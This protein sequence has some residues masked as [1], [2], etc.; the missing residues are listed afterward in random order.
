MSAFL[1][2]LLYS[3]VW[4]MCVCLCVCGVAAHTFTSIVPPCLC[5][6]VYINY[7]WRPYTYRRSYVEY[8]S[9]PFSV[10]VKAFVLHFFFFLFFFFI[11]SLKYLLHCI[12]SEEFCMFTMEMMM[13]MGGKRKKKIIQDIAFL[14][15]S[16][17]YSFIYTLYLWLYN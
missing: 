4:W 1:L 5:D 9:L 2:R 15:N 16:V 13:M 17:L 14:F 6:D 7:A 12:I 8:L 11:F 10:T 3:L